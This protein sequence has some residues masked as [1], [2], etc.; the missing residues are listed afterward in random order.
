M[1]VTGSGTDDVGTF[2]IEGIYSDKTNRIGLTKKYIP[3]TGNP[4][5]NLGHE[6][7]IQLEWNARTR[8]FDGKWYIQTS[9]YE[10]SNKYEIKFDGTSNAV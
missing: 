6:V 1:R 8:Q 2:T 4:S 5:Q 9:E 7:T 3:G 10:H